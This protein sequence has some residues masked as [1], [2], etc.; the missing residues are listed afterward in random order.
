MDG[1]GAALAA[2]LKFGEGADYFYAAYGEPP[3]SPEDLWGRDVYVVDFSYPRNVLAEMRK[4]ASRVMVI[5]HH[6]T[7]QAE[8]EGVEGCIFDMSKSG[9]VLA[10]E[11]FRPDKPVPELF[12]YIQDRDLWKW[13][14]PSSK[15]ISAFLFSLDGMDFRKLAPFVDVPLNPETLK[16][17]FPNGTPLAFPLHEGGAILRSQKQMIDAAARGAVLRQI[18]DH[19][20]YAV[21]ATVLNSEI[22]NV[23]AQ[24]MAD[25][26][27]TGNGR[28]A[29]WCY[30][31][32]RERFYVSCRG[33]GNVDVT[34][35]AKLFGGGGHRLAAGFECTKLPWH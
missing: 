13:E 9:A 18:G 32:T 3:P 6:K 25:E 12:L 14:L 15:E 21:N 34:E 26:T 33:V 8:L 23:L 11:F 19:T 31:E 20:F 22:G 1:F 17:M 29:I 10:W 35:T 2:W 28:A 16:R 7:A 24:R 30:D 4:V 27:G 5:D